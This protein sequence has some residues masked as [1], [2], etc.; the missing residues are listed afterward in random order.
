[1]SISRRPPEF[2]DNTWLAWCA[3]LNLTP[4]ELL[5]L[6]KH[7]LHTFGPGPEEEAGGAGVREP[8]KPLLP[9]GSFGLALELPNGDVGS[10]VSAST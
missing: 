5:A 9:L 2:T 8:R 1:M 7:L 10:G 6:K 3:I 4:K